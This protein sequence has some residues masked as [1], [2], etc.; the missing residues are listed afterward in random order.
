[1]AAPSAPGLAS[2]VPSLGGQAGAGEIRCGCLEET[3]NPFPL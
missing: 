3:Y 2:L 1:M